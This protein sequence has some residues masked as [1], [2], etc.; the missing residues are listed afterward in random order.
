MR[1]GFFARLCGCFAFVPGVVGVSAEAQDLTL[2]ADLPANAVLG[3]DHSLTLRLLPAKEQKVVSLPTADVE[4]VIRGGSGVVHRMSWERIRVERSGDLTETIQVDK[5]SIVLQKGSESVRRINIFSDMDVLLAPGRYDVTVLYEQKIKAQ[6]SFAVRADA[7][8]TVPLLIG[9]IAGKELLPRYWAR[10]QL[11][12]LAG[13]PSW[14]PAMEDSAE[15]IAARAAELRAWWKAN[16][17]E[18]V[19]RPTFQKAM[20]PDGVTSHPASP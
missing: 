6:G 2:A 8:Q 11:F 17:T 12:A 10:T 9:A 15:M 1:L 16:K 14:T 4:V 5:E 20:T 19:K 7:E 13:V 3:G 18:V